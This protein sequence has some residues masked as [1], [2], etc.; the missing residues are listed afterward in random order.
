M[1]R[2]NDHKALLVPF[3]AGSGSENN[4]ERY[5]FLSAYQISGSISACQRWQS[6]RI[7]I[8]ADGQGSLYRAIQDEDISHFDR[9][10][11]LFSM[12]ACVITSVSFN[13][14]IVW[15][16]AGTGRMIESSEDLRENTVREIRIS[17]QNRSSESVTGELFYIA[18][19]DTHSYRVPYHT[20]SWEGCIGNPVFTLYNDDY[21]TEADFSRLRED[22]RREPYRSLYREW[23]DR[24][25]EFLHANPEAEIAN[26]IGGDGAGYMRARKFQDGMRVCAIVGMTEKNPALLVMACRFALSCA[27]SGNWCADDMETVPALTWRHRSFSENEISFSVALV[28]SICGHTLTYSGRDILVHALLQ[29][30][31]ARIEDDLLTVNYIYSCNQGLVFLYGYIRSLTALLRDFPRMEAKLDMAESMFWEM[32]DLYI[33]QDGSTK[34][35]AGYWSFTFI[36]VMRILYSLAKRHNKTVRDYIAG[37]LDRTSAYGI[38]LLD[39]KGKTLPVSDCG[40]SGY[41]YAVADGFYTLTQDPRWAQIIAL[42]ADSPDILEYPMYGA[43]PDMRAAADTLSHPEFED[44]P[45]AGMTAVTRNGQ[46]LICIAGNSNRTHSH[47]DKGSFLLYD[48]G[49]MLLCDKGSAAYDSANPGWAFCS[50]GHNMAVPVEADGSYATQ[51]YDDGLRAEYTASCQNGRFSWSADL[52]PLWKQTG[53]VISAHRTITSDDPY[54]YHIT[55]TFVCSEPHAVTVCFHCADPAALTIESG[56]PGAVL[57]QHEESQDAERRDGTVG[58]M[59]MITVTVPAACTVRIETTVII[60]S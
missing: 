11:V 4:R 34:E 59:V 10:C 56:T 36:H 21:F 12:P 31:L 49:V 33:A 46:R 26:S 32:L 38:F 60:R 52:T 23:H 16:Q 51:I 50:A 28:Y 42:S 6:I 15:E 27:A 39:A 58:K 54:V 2:M 44:F 7:S 48:G 29:K 1:Y 19:E 20:S 43:V 37:R 14:K 18:A 41:Y 40:R 45:D 3:Y 17:V 53:Y 30:G 13:E 9:I 35:G 22:I 25:E 57:A 5:Q 47:A 24:A 8:P 55:D